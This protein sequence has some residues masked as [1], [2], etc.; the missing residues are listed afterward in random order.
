MA[1]LRDYSREYTRLGFGKDVRIKAI[2]RYIFEFIVY[3]NYSVVFFTIASSIASLEK[4]EKLGSF[5]IVIGVFL[6]TVVISAILMM[7][8]LLLFLFIRYYY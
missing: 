8:V 4:S 2:R 1:P 3:R 5:V 7:I 6:S